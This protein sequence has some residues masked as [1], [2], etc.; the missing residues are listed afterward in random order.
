MLLVLA[1]L[2]AC[3]SDDESVVRSLVSPVPKALAVTGGNAQTGFV[4][5]DLDT[6]LT[7][8]I[9]DA[10]GLAIVGYPVAWAVTAGGGTLSADTATTNSYGVSTVTWTLGNSAAPQSVTANPAGVPSLSATFTATAVAPNFAIDTGN[11]QTAAAKDTVADNPTIIVTDAAGDPV[12]GVRVDFAIASGGGFL[13]GGAK[14]SAQTASINTDSKGLAAITWVLGSTVGTQTMTATVGDATPL[15]FTAVATA[16]LAFNF[17]AS[18]RTI[19]LANNRAV[20]VR[21]RWVG[22]GAIR[23]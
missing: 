2:N 6:S 12:T 3:G 21:V 16:P 10:N 1:G 9:T 20:R 5:S 8:A 23:S 15:T 19:L 13:S 7:V 4:T 22:A 18:G 11:N 14:D 17:E